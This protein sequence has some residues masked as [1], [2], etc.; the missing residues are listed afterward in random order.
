MAS[1][2]EQSFQEFLRQQ[3][4]GNRGSA[5]DMLRLLGFVSLLA[6]GVFW[7]PLQWQLAGPTSPGE[8]AIA[9]AFGSFL[10]LGPP[11]FVSFFVPWSPAAQLLNKINAKTAGQAVALACSLYLLFYAGYLLY[12]WW[13]VRPMVAATNTAALQTILGVIATVIAPALLWAPV[14]SDE[15]EEVLKQDQLVKR[16][17]MQAKLDIAYLQS[18]VLEAQRMTAGELAAVAGQVGGPELAQRMRWL[19]SSIDQTIGEIAHTVGTTAGTLERFPSLSGNQQA[20]QVLEYVGESLQHITQQPLPA[21]GSTI[22]LAPAGAP[23]TL[24]AAAGAPWSTAPLPDAACATAPGRVAAPEGPP[25]ATTDAPGRALGDAEDAYR[26]ARRTLTKAAWRRSD[27]EICLSC[28]KTA[29]LELI[30]S[31]RAAGRIVEL[32]DPR[33]HYSWK[34]A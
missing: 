26:T 14:S 10:M 29:A 7:Y 15:L 9:V 30:A 28:S 1:Q 16:Y 12:H 25:G 17:E 27:L 22:D 21:V 8:M 19:L 24:L 6:S 18:M 33:H 13:S 4:A 3:R 5:R 23:A 20:V 2:F 31:W 34:D 11:V 32:T